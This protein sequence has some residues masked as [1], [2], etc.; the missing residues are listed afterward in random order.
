MIVAC[1]GSLHY[2]LLSKIDGRWIVILGE[3]PVHPC[4]GRLEFWQAG[5]CKMLAY[6]A[7]KS[8]ISEQLRVNLNARQSKIHDRYSVYLYL[9]GNF[10]P[11]QS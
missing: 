7:H 2:T 1:Y 3:S 8:Y 6:F 5:S 11:G 9:N 10:T 4:F